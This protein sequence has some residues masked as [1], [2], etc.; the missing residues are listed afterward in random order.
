MRPA[1]VLFAGLALIAL[2]LALG[3]ILFAPLAVIRSPLVPILLILA[4]VFAVCL[5][6][7]GPGSRLLGLAL[8]ALVLTGCAT[9]PAGLQQTVF[10]MEGALATAIDG[11]TAY[12]NLPSCSPA[13]APGSLCSDPAVVARMR[14]A[15]PAA[16]SAV[17]A[18]EASVRDPSASVAAQAAAVADAGAAIGALTALLPKPAAAASPAPAAAAH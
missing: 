1:A 14:V 5:F 11:A 8:G 10:T 16:S 17:L 3:L 4:F 9:T 6:R 13:L 15:A 12:K 7:V 18:A 2:G